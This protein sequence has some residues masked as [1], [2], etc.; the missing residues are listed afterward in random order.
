SLVLPKAKADHVYHIYPVLTEYRDELQ[1]YLL[2]QGIQTQIHYPLAP[3][4]QKAYNEWHA[5]HFPITE[6]IA[7]QEL[8]I[9]C[10]QSMTDEDVLKII[11]ALNAWKP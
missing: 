6:K 3:H 11:D 2:Q 4:Q 1:R 7:A 5:L 8:S 10:N 9:P